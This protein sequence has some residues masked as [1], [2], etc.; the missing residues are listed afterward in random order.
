[1][2]CSAT[3]QFDAT[4]LDEALAVRDAAVC[5]IAEESPATSRNSAWLVVTELITNVVRH[6]P[7]PAEVRLEAEQ[8]RVAVHVLD[9]GPGG[10]PAAHLPEDPLSEGG[11]GL[12][13]VSRLAHRFEMLARFEGGSHAIAVLDG[14]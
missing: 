2:G 8:G 12:Y 14:V 11:R 4:V 6:A 5:T 3:W 13:I 1:M 9:R 10:V 7:G